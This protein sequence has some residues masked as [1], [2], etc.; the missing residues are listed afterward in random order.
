VLESGGA[1][2]H[3]QLLLFNNEDIFGIRTQRWKYVKY[4][5]FRDHVESFDVRGF[6]E[7]FDLDIDPAEN[8]SVASLHP[9]VVAEMERR[10][11]EANRIFGPMKSMNLH[12]GKQPARD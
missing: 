1:S 2:P 8:Y 6:T 5:Y 3:D 7:L 12:E 9:D 10:M 4:T 11:A